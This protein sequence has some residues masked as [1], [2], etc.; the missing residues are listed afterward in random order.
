MAAVTGSKQFRMVVVP[1][2]PVRKV[3]LSLVLILVGMA[4]CF[5]S[6]YWG[7]RLAG[8]ELAVLRDQNAGLQ[9]KLANLDESH[10]EALQQLANLRL[11]AEVDQQANEGVRQEILTLKSQIAELE[12]DITF[13]R[14]LMAP[15]ADKQ[16]LSIGALNIVATSQPR[17]FEYTL[18]V[19]QLATSHEL[20]KGYV[21]VTVVG[22]EAGVSKRVPLKLLSSDIADEDIKLRFKYFQTLHGE[23]VLPDGFDP[24]RIEVVAVA[25]GRNSAR[26][27]QKYGWLVQQ[28]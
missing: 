22:Y 6:Y 14:G 3:V 1:Y 15:T 23:L 17:H 4:A 24:E 19:Q 21:N 8:A 7:L 20:L 5:A 16:G 9:V 12:E 13:Y 27:E 11:G 2:R 25:T 18:V 10:T 26:I 28:P